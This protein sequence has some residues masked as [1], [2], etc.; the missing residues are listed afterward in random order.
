MHTSIFILTLTC[1][2]RIK[3]SFLFVFFWNCCQCT[4]Q[5]IKKINEFWW[6]FPFFQSHL[7]CRIFTYHRWTIRLLFENRWRIKTNIPFFSSWRLIATNCR[8]HY[9]PLS[10]YDVPIIK[11]RPYHS[12]LFVVFSWPSDVSELPYPWIS[13]FILFQEEHTGM[14]YGDQSAGK[15]WYK[16]VSRRRVWIRIRSVPKF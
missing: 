7:R 1:A 12:Y 2:L 10:D 16:S 13:F 5:F 4:V 11:I 6:Q 3:K 15:T 9:V 14:S 8:C